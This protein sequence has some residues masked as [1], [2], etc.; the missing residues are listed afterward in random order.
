L[1]GEDFEAVEEV[2]EMSGFEVQKSAFCKVRSRVS[3]RL[4]R[5]A[6]EAI[7]PWGVLLG[8]ILYR[9]SE[10]ESGD[11]NRREVLLLEIIGT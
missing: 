8:L 11:L 2:T 9:A 4:R 1:F 7:I 10:E 6:F 5:S 3:G